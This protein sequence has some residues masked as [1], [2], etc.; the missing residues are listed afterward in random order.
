MNFL[1]TR[2]DHIFH[3]RLRERR[4]AWHL[5]YENEGPA[6]RNVWALTCADAVL[7]NASVTVHP[8]AACDV[9]H[10]GCANIASSQRKDTKTCKTSPILFPRKP[11]V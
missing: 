6:R 7:S 1:F 9:V 5:Q 8:A 3:E 11:S 4:A 2:N 10:T